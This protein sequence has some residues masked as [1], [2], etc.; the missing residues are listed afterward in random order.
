MSRAG[1]LCLGQSDRLMPSTAHYCYQIANSYGVLNGCLVGICFHLEGFGARLLCLV[2]V[3]CC[4]W[5]ARG[6]FLMP[7]LGNSYSLCAGWEVVMWEYETVIVRVSLCD[8]LDYHLV[9]L[10]EWLRVRE[11]NIRHYL[12]SSSSW[13]PRYSTEAELNMYLHHP[14]FV[15]NWLVECTIPHAYFHFF[16]HHDNNPHQNIFICHYLLSQLLFYFFPHPNTSI[17][18]LLLLT[19]TT[20]YSKIKYKTPWPALLTC[21]HPQKKRQQHTHKS[22][23]AGGNITHKKKPKKTTTDTIIVL[24]SMQKY[25]KK[26]TKTGQKKP[27]IHNRQRGGGMHE[28]KNAWYHEITNYPITEW[29]VVLKK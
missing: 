10:S 8:G 2:R 20:T 7:Y 22:I 13:V 15:F 27:Q 5:T 1:F 26:R 17:V 24:L 14:S 29:M 11:W 16:T 6:A 28:K 21:P 9:A 12:R 23:T 4:F 25:T 18:P 19:T 3:E